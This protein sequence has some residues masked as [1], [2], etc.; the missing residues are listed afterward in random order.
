MMGTASLELA[1]GGL[2]SAHAVLERSHGENFPVASRLLAPL[3]RRHLLAIYGFARLADE[4]GDEVRGDRLA[5]LDWLAGELLRA[6][7]GEAGH[8]LLLRLRRTLAECPLPREAFIRLID[9]N[10]LDQTACR[11]ETWGQLE[12]YCELS[13]NPVGE[14]VLCVFKLATPERI[15]LSR[16]VCT[17][18]QLTEHLQDLAEDVNRGRFYLPAEDLARFGCSHEQLS[19]LV[20]A[21]GHG[22]DLGGVPSGTTPRSEDFLRSAARTREAISFETARARALLAA[23]VPLVAG[24]RGR[25]KLAL[26][27]F[28]AGG[29]AALDAIERADFDVLGGVPRVR[30]GRL[31]WRLARVLMKARA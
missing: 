7:A 28:L 1:P 12:A 20:S 30:R 11:Y 24:V 19:L 5:A 17:G 10:R 9:A 15:E 25:P 6:Y 14:L 16:L 8:P 23:G 4:L 29:Q 21:G 27:G 26:A 18:L 3:Q 31:L 2:P 13:A 22:L